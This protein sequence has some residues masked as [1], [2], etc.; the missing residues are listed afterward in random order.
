MPW[1]ILSPI[2]A[3]ITALVGWYLAE[4]I[5]N[6]NKA[7]TAATITEAAVK[8]VDQR[9]EDIKE[10]KAERAQLRLYIAYLLGGIE[11]L[12]GQI[13]GDAIVF[14]PKTLEEFQNKP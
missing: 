6:K 14:T 8:L 7:D 3:A 11:A 4:S 1:D 12:R 5:R 2:G 10:L 9:D 13:K